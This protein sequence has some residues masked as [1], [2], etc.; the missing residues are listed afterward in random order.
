MTE[1]S[2]PPVEEVALLPCPFCGSDAAG[3]E[4]GV[5]GPDGCSSTV[6]CDVCHASAATEYSDGQAAANW[7]TRKSLRPELPP[8]DYCGIVQVDPA[9]FERAELPHDA[10]GGNG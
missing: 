10:E 3:F 1:P 9:D 2:S 8:T 4:H 5:Y 6:F 7:N